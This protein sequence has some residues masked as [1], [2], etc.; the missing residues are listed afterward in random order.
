[1]LHTFTGSILTGS[2][3]HRFTA[4][5]VAFL[6]AVLCL[7][8]PAARF[9]AHAA[10][11]AA[12]NDTPTPFVVDNNVED[13]SVGAGLVYWANNCAGDEFNPIAELRRKPAGGGS[14]QVIQT[15]DTNTEPNPPNETCITYA[16]QVSS[17]DG[18]FYFEDDFVSDDR[19]MRMPLGEPFT[20][21]TVTTLA[22]NERPL[23]GRAFVED[24]DYLYWPV[25]SQSK[26]LRIRKDGSGTIETVADTEPSP[27][28]ILIVGTT[29]YWTDSVGVWG[30]SIGC[31][32]L[33]CDG[34]TKYDD[35]PDN[36]FAY[37]LVYK[38]VSGNFPFSGGFRLYWVLRTGSNPNYTYQ[39]VY[40]A[41]SFNQICF[42]EFA[43]DPPNPTPAPPAPEPFY[44]ASVNR[45]IGDLVLVDNNIFWT[46]GGGG[47][48]DG[49]FRKAYDA[50]AVNAPDNIATNQDGIDPRLFVVNDR[51][52]FARNASGLGAGDGIYT[53]SLN[54]TAITRDFVMDAFE[55]TQGIQNLANEAPL[56]G[57]KATYVRAYGK[58]I[59]G[60]STPNVE[61]HLVGTRND[62]ALPGSP[63]KP[64]NGVRALTTGGSYDRARLN[65]GWYFLL[66]PSWTEPGN[67]KLQV[68]I[69]PRHLHTD[70]NLANN[71]FPADAPKQVNFQNQPPVCVMTVPVRT[72]N[73]LPSVYDPNVGL[74]VSNFDRRWPVPETWVFR[75]TEPVEELEIC[76]WYG[77]PYPCFGPYELS[78]GW[79]LTNGIPDRDK[80]IS[81]LWTRAL[82]SFNPDACDDIGA[83]V[84]FMGM[85][86][87]DADNGGASGYASTISNQS[88]VQLPEHGAISP[89]WDAM[90]EGSTMAQELAH[91]HGRKHVN[92]GGPDNI[93]NGYLY[94]PCQ[95]ANVGA[96]SYYGFDIATRQPI[97]PDQAADFMSYAYRTWVSDYTWKA[98]LN[99]F[100]TTTVAASAPLAAAQGEQVFVTGLV[101]GENP[102]G[103]ITI[104]LNV[105]AASLPPATQQLAAANTASVQHGD[106]PHVAYSLRLLDADGEV[107]ATHPLTLQPLDDHSEESKA[108][109]FVDLF[110]KPATQIAQMQ[111]LADDAVIISK[112][113][114]INLPVA[115][116]QAPAAGAVVDD[117]LTIQWTASDPDAADRLKF[118]V[119]YSHDNG[120]SW[121]TLAINRPSTPELSN[122]LTISVAGVLQGSATNAALVRVL[123]SDGINTQTATSPA[124]TVENSPPYVAIALPTAGETLIGGEAVLLQGIA[125]DPEDGGLSAS[126]LTWQMDGGVVGTGATLAVG[127]LGS[128]THQATLAATDANSQT[129]T[130]T[131]SFDIAP[132]GVPLAAAPTLDGACND[133]SYTTSINLPLSLYGDDTQANVR[134][135]RSDDYLWAC[136]YNLVGGDETPGSYVGLRADLDNSRDALAQATDVGFFVGENGDV[137][138]RMGDGTGE[139]VAPG[140][141]GLQGQVVTDTVGWSAEL[142]IEKDQL[143]GWG[144]VINLAV[145]QHSLTAEGDDYVWPFLAQWG[146]PNTWSEAAL[147][148]QPIIS[149]ISPNAVVKQDASVATTLG[150]SL[151]MTVVGTSLVSGTQVLWDGAVLPTTYITAAVLSAQVTDTLLSDAGIFAVTA[152]S[153]DGL[154]SNPVQFVVEGVLPTIS[155]FSP[156]SATAESATFTL[157]INGSNFAANAQAFW[158]GM[159]LPTEFVN[160]A[161]L[162]VTVSAELLQTSGTAGITVENPTPT[163]QQ[164]AVAPYVVAAPDEAS[165]QL[166]NFMPGLYK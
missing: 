64:I 2:T 32:T 138:T 93:D 14:P 10:V 45:V 18:L 124:F 63:L 154:T 162:K 137:F 121:R 31:A 70:P 54:A 51:L 74:M 8:S 57:D 75:D 159:A 12:V 49:V 104:I 59:A 69:D 22:S 24:G 148:I 85:V 30:K 11:Q 128:T 65:D 117:E 95:I 19:I 145:G 147:G 136:F 155:G 66:P 50:A 83:P 88:W 122:T 150:P 33:P 164:S 90:S 160:A 26:I 143:G 127:G 101:D 87:P 78:D 61:V 123:A 114:G 68:V 105:P 94:P 133:A 56:V 9:T 13:W 86:H 113:A 126:A 110:P 17:G 96:D 81:S 134:L 72:H 103:E 36:A 48:G 125:T 82:L 39:I 132:V 37:G 141:G 55:V 21:E 6:F 129:V 130:T 109:L 166:Q 3:A 71:V 76:T 106:E 91:N 16:Y 79:G 53:L 97:R 100:A 152:Q 67:T 23:S 165:A 108:F 42:L 28:D 84:H 120:A 29:I 60:P 149:Q 102:R 46:E 89:A 98:L 139:F 43:P 156:I 44:T 73:P 116:I 7:F 20:P 144:H 115:A 47:A 161:Q 62:L 119:Q 27:L 135:L 163:V 142:R 40:R 131:V 41:C 158:N 38:A 99:K 153:P 92:C 15:V 25:T 118:T 157:T 35:F 140:P 77:V 4:G 1:M 107:I 52:Y 151:T 112:T 5:G 34:K 58:Q 111:L 146:A 80:V